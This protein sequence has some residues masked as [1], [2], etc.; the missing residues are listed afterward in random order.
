MPVPVGTGTVKMAVVFFQIVSE[1]LAMCQVPTGNGIA[2]LIRALFWQSAL[3]EKKKGSAWQC[4]VVASW[5]DAKLPSL[6]GI[7]NSSRIKSDILPKKLGFG[8][9]RE[10]ENF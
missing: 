7:P 2:N 6:A 4:Q 3:P 5:Q 8:S 10:R 9:G 1:Q